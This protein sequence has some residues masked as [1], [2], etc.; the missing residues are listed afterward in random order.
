MKRKRLLL[1]CLCLSLF[2]LINGC[3]NNAEKKPITPTPQKKTTQTGEMTASER[4][5]M[6]SQLSKMAEEV[7][8]V[9]K[10]SVVV[11]DVRMNNNNETTRTP[12]TTTNNNTTVP[13]PGTTTNNNGIS[14][15]PTPG[16]MEDAPLP[17]QNATNNVQNR[18]MNDDIWINSDQASGIIV[19]VGLTVDQAITQDQT[20]MGAVETKVMN[21]LKASDKRITQ[22]LVS[23]DPNIIKRI[24]DIATG[25]IEGKP[26]KTFQKDIDDLN[27]RFRESRPVL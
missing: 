11:A 3:A 17:S 25:I 12:G 6:A 16:T 23:T 20:K 18:N 5:V 1:L 21:K 8:G 24:N 15:N 27:F 9:N 4:R 22:V 19:M 14:T 26:I 2:L 7:E 13:T 10:A